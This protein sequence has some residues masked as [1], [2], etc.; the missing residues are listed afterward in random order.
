MSVMAIAAVAL[1]G[2]SSGSGAS[3]PSSSASAKGGIPA[4]TIT[5]MAADYGT[6]P[7]SANYSGKWWAKVVKAFNKKYPQVT[8]KM[9]VIPWG[10]AA[11]IDAKITAAVQAGN[12]PD[13]AQGSA[14]WAGLQSQVYP[15][16]D[17]L[18]PAVLND[19]TPIFAKQ[20][21]IGGTAYGIPWVA[22]SRALV[23]N[24][25]LFAK[26]GISAPPT[27]WAEYKADAQKLKSAGVQTPACVPFGAEEAQAEFLIWTLG[28]DGGYVNAAGKWAIDSPQ[29]VETFKF[30][31]QLKTAGLIESS[32]GTTNRTSGSNSCWNQFD[33][34]HVGMTNS[35]NAQIPM[36]KSA[37]V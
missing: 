11:G 31:N 36:L 1:A 5:V 24:K 29:N 7:T 32:T 22:S 16:K 15:A 10:G 2:C 12:P 3:S 20:G 13:I 8:V 17:V 23:Y 26:A 37:G 6:G 28:N 34:G 19:L 35:Q 27:S 14:D 9:D 25:D 21:D 4:T 30:L 33:A 18:T